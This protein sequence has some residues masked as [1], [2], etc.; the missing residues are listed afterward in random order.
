MVA[1]FFIRS[2][3]GNSS[4]I[5]F[6]TMDQIAIKNNDISLMRSFRTMSSSRW[7]FARTMVLING[8][9]I[10]FSIRTIDVD[11]SVSGIV[12]GSQDMY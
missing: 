4:S 11:P 1:S 5:K 2:E 3:D 8:D 6:G 10:A 7:A 9:L 12:I